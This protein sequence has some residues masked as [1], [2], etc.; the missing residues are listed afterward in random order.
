MLWQWHV[1]VIIVK[2]GV[3]FGL[4]RFNVGIIDLYQEEIGT[5]RKAL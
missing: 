4:M 5:N 1:P 2:L 3:L